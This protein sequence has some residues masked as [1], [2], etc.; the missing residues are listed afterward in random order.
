MGQPIGIAIGTQNAVLS[1]R[2]LLLKH[3][4]NRAS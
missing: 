1:S 4:G 2:A 3:P